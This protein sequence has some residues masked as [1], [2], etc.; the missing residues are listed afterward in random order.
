MKKYAGFLSVAALAFTVVG[1]SD[2]MS[3]AAP[4]SVSAGSTMSG[5]DEAKG[6]RASLPTIAGAAVANPNFSTLVY[7]LQKAGLVE[8]FSGNQQFTVFA[9]TNA[10][11][12]AAA[13]ALGA[14]NGIALIDSLDVDTLTAILKYH[15]ALG[16]RRAQAVLSSGQVRMLDGN[17]AAITVDDEGAKIDGA[18]ITD[19]D[20]VVSNGIIHVLGFVMLP[21]SIG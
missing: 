16:D 7:A 14:P 13:A 21:P 19:T 17:W 6:G 11:F 18:L 15:V 3:P 8:T 5:S 9:P 2:S 10:A 12:D 4:S 1:C 20:I